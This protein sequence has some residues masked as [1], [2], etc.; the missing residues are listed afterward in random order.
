MNVKSFEDFC[1]ILDKSPI[2][3]NVVYADSDGNIGYKG[4]LLLL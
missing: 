3:L 2:P 4:I 1:K